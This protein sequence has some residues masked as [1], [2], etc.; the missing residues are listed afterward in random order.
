M[1]LDLKELIAKLTNTPMVV[2]QGTSGIWTYRKWSDGT[3]ECWG[4]YSDTISHNGTVFGG[5]AY[6]VTVNFPTGLFVALPVV[7][8]S[9][10]LGNQYALTGTINNAF[11]TSSVNLFAVCNTSGSKST[12][13][14]ITV[15]GKWK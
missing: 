2:E 13:W 1:K 7:E 12:S 14:F 9:A 10:Y 8:Y 3:A 11:T 5:Y 6:T 4:T 15:I